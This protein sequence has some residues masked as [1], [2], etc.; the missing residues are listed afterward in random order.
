MLLFSQLNYAKCIT[1]LQYA[2]LLWRI[3]FLQ[4]LIRG[5]E[6]EERRKKARR[7]KERET[8]IIQV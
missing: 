6:K 7:G 8:K 5:Q 1:K 4:K 3:T 2:T